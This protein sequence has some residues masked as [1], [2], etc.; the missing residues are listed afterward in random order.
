M[1]AFNASGQLIHSDLVSNTMG[2][3]TAVGVGDSAVNFPLFA[4]KGTG[5]NDSV[6]LQFADGSIDD[7]GISGDFGAGTLSFTASLLLPGSAGSAP[8]Q[9][10]NQGWSPDPFYPDESLAGGTGAG[11]TTLEG[12]QFVEQ[13]ANGAFDNVFA[14]SGYGDAT[15]EGTLYA[16]NQLNLALPGWHVVDAGGV[17]AEI[18]PIT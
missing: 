13:L 11:G 9:A 12:V 1:L 2:L 18:F 17:A 16:S 4:G 8:V 14:D 10:V 6:V 15:H 3:P 5:Q 7:A